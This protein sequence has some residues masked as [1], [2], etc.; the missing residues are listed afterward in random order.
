MFKFKDYYILEVGDKVVEGDEY[1][2]NHRYT[3]QRVGK[4]H[5][6]LS[7]AFKRTW[8]PR[9]VIMIVPHVRWCITRRKIKRKII[10]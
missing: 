2:F 10:G 7:E 4:S 6:L 8:T 1:I 9:T 3:M 5:A